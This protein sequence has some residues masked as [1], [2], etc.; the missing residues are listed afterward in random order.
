MLAVSEQLTHDPTALDWS[1]DGSLIAV[2]DRNG[3]CRILDANTL[4]V[5]GSITNEFAGKKDTWIEDIK[6]SPDGKTIAFGY[7]G[8]LS[9]VELVEVTAQKKL[10]KVAS[11]KI[12]LTSALSHLDWS[13]DG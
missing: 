1:P 2:G 6:F 13:Q 8:G 9:P 3:T 7:H 5:L 11:A 12:G 10:R 4:Q